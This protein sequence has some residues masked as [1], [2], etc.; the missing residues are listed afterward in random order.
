MAFKVRRLD[1]W[2]KREAEV[3]RPVNNLHAMLEEKGLVVY[4]PFP[5]PKGSAGVRA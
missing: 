1:G 4:R 2:P 5:L 3:Y